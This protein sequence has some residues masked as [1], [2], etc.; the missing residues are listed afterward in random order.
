MDLKNRERKDQ[1]ESYSKVENK[2]TL[3]EKVSSYLRLPKDSRQ[4]LHPSDLDHDAAVLFLSEVEKDPNG[5][6]LAMAG[7]EL[8]D[9]NIVY[10]AEFCLDARDCPIVDCNGET[11]GVSYYY[12]KIIAL[13]P[14]TSSDWG[15][16][17]PRFKCAWG[18][19]SQRTHKSVEKNPYALLTNYLWIPPQEYYNV[20]NVF[21]KEF[22]KKAILRIAGTP[23]I[24]QA[25]C[26]I[27][28]DI[29]NNS[30]VV[31]YNRDKEIDVETNIKQLFSRIIDEQVDIAV[32]PEM[33][34]TSN[35]QNIVSEIM[36]AN[37]EK[38]LP[39]ITLLPTREYCMGNPPKTVNELVALDQ[40]GNII[41]KYNKQ[42][43]FQ[44]DIIKHDNNDINSSSVIPLYEPIKRDD[45]LYILHIPNI[46]RI[47]VAICSDFLEKELRELLFDQYE[48]SLLLHPVCS[49]G[50]DLLERDYGDAMRNYCDVLECNTCAAFDPDI[51]NGVIISK[52]ISPQKPC[53]YFPYGH[54]DQK[55]VSDMVDCN[56]K[57]CNG[58]V[59]I[60][61]VPANY[62]KRTKLSQ[63]IKF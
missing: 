63:L 58:C 23:V 51:I 39:S 38:Q 21:L 28:P 19:Q 45:M 7:I 17:L 20:Q 15:T 37:W 44:L 52:N 12:K 60:Y 14:N 9:T 53:K 43:P 59:Y 27:H 22:P 25:P 11:I 1:F 24:N 61:E 33:L 2:K 57:P 13:N 56:G 50:K 3:K 41:F 46:G 47:G 35:C 29:V 8:I 40:D 6:W 31:S 48:I 5:F 54:S 34:G 4:L 62:K 18:K 49:F 10:R 36:K 55:E 16:I 26:T 30:Y 42:Y 32:F